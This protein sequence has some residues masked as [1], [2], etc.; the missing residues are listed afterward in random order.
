MRPGYLIVI[1]LAGLAACAFA[2]A[3][4]Q[5]LGRPIVPAPT[6]KDFRTALACACSLLIVAVT[7]GVAPLPVCPLE[8]S[9]SCIWIA[10]VQGNGIGRTT[11][12]G[13]ENA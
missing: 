11:V 5:T 8:D 3:V 13:P 9:P 6:R 7:G 2:Y 12:N 1:A 10:P 4:G